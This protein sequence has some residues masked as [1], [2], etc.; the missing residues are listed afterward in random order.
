M[1][2]ER[3]RLVR[4]ME[5]ARLKAETERLRDALLS[6]VSHDLRTPLVAIIGSVTS[7]LTYGT[8]YDEATRRDLL[9]TIQEEAERLNRFVGNLL[10]MMRLEAGE[11]Q[12]NRQWVDIGDV[13]GTA[14]SRL[15]HAL[16][17]H[18][19]AVE[20]TPDL[21]ALWLD[22]VLVEHVLINGL[23]NAAKS[24]PPGTTIRV[25]A[26]RRDDA[27]VVAVVD[28]G[29]GVSPADLERIF[30]KFYRVR[31]GDRQGA[32]TGLGLSICRGIVEAHGGRIVARS[33]ANGKGMAFVVTLPI[34]KEPPMPD[35]G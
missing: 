35:E 19:L 27:M 2:I 13:I 12:L 21:S 10:D 14:T 28:E 30:D 26:R 11:L 34:D 17:Q 4:E 5:Q 33:P 9:A 8:S 15:R 31:R 25:E 22:F 29:A 24:S 7:L 3:T 6:S 23:E 16:S 20:V 18:R 1:A 32:G